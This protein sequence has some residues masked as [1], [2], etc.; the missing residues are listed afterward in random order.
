MQTAAINIQPEMTILDLTERYPSTLQVLV[1]AGFPKMKD[2]EKRRT[3]GKVLTIASAAK[4][5]GLDAEELVR[6]LKDAARADQEQADV[7]LNQAEGLTLL[8]PGDL[9]HSGLLPCPVRIPILEAVAELGR[10]L[11]ADTGKALGWSLAAAS[12]G[13]DGLNQQLATV[14]DEGDLPDVFICAGF[15][16]FFDQKNFRRFK[17]KDTFVDLA[18]EGQNACFGDLQLRDPEGHFTMVGMVPAVFLVNKNQLGDDPEP[19]TWEDVLHPRFR[20]RVALPVGDFD[21]FNGMLL[22]LHKRFGDEGIRS[23]ASNMLASLHPSQTVGRFSG[24]QPEQP[25]ISIIPYFFSRMTLKSKVIKTVWPEDG[26]IICPIFMLVKRSSLPEAK[27]IAD[28]FLSQEVGEVLAHRGLFP[29]LNPE[30]DNK[31]PEGSQFSWLGWDYIREIDIGELIPRLDKL[32]QDSLAEAQGGA[33]DGSAGGGGPKNGGAP[34]GSA[35][36]GSPQNGG[37]PDGSAGG[38]GAAG[39]AQRGGSPQNGGAS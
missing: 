33:P 11:E 27:A 37:A 18:P 9:S 14:V 15:E 32:F 5:R 23:L 13:V 20:N 22:T 31:L 39:R 35:G 8:P 26:A 36:G 24:K 29:V 38:G 2:A 34:D 19:R 3:Q 4:L 12:V 28:V 25:T 7:T 21:L 10:K 16:T 6:K 17:D 1:D 30:V